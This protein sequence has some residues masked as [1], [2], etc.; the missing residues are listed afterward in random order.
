MMFDADVGFF[1]Q[2]PRYYAGVSVKN[3]LELKG[4]DMS[5]NSS[6]VIRY[7]TDRTF[8]LT[9]AYYY[10]LNQDLLISPAFMIMSDLAKTQLMVAGNFSYRNK[11]FGGLSYRLFESIGLIAG[12]KIKDFKITYSY[13]VVT[14]RYGMPGSHEI[15]LRYCFK[16]NGD[17]SKT[18]Y[19]NTRFL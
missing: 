14:I 16:I 11:F 10:S 9:G 13:D 6:T 2:N 19:K 12:V 8:Y 3:L 4:K 17:N 7:Q 18:S 1:L 5:K 15:G